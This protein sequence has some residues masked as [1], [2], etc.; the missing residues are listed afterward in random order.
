LSFNDT[1]NS[2]FS[3]INCSAIQSGTEAVS[4]SI[5]AMYGRKPCAGVIIKFGKIRREHSGYC[6]S[7]AC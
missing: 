2:S 4:E 3:V 7:L 6:T 1:P 5:V